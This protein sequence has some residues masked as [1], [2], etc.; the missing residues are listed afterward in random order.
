MVSHRIRLRFFFLAFFPK[1][2]Y[3]YY[4]MDGNPLL[5]SCGILQQGDKILALRRKDG[6]ELGGKWEFPGG[7][8]EQGETPEH[9]LVRELKE[10]LDLQVT[11]GEALPPV[12]HTYP[13]FTIILYPFVCSSPSVI[14]FM[15]DHDNLIW[16]APERLRSLDWAGA[17][18][19]VLETYIQRR[20]ENP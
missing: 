6:S 3:H 13:L 10:E 15:K 4:P 19:L 9:C 11:V 7:K 5:V 14:E 12:R 8:I 1:S 17:D 20:S 2:P 18:R 16:D